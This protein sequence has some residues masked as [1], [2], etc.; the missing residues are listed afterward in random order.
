MR[1]WIMEE[2]ERERSEDRYRKK[3]ERDRG[4]RVDTVN[5]AERNF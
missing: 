3:R 5:G 1:G 4:P 2:R